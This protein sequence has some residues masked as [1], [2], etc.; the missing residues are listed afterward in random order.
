MV[1]W[2]VRQVILDQKALI[3]YILKYQ[4]KGEKKSEAFI[5]AF[6]DLLG[7][8]VEKGQSMRTVMTKTMNKSIAERDY[9]SVETMH[10][11]LGLPYVLCSRAQVRHQQL[12][13]FT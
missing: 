6:K 2:I 12:E 1:V 4:L 8:G 9:T 7:E 10:Q 3:K 13:S 5:M 11:C